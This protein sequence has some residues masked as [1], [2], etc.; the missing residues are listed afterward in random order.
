MHCSLAGWE[1]AGLGAGEQG[2]Q[3]PVK[4][5]EVRDKKDKYKVRRGGGG[6]GRGEE[7]RNIS[8]ISVFP[9]FSSGRRYFTQRPF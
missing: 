8:N 3:E 2:I 5:G 4:G 9:A 6:E 1:G 7:R